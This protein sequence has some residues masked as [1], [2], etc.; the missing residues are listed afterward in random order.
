MG[1]FESIA[2]VEPQRP[3]AFYRRRIITCWPFLRLSH[4][5]LFSIAIVLCVCAVESC[6]SSNPAPPPPP[7]PPIKVTQTGRITDILSKHPLSGVTIAG[8]D[9][10]ATTN[11]N[12][13]YSLTYTKGTAPVLTMSKANYVTRT[14][15]PAHGPDY[16]NIPDS[17]NMTEF[18]NICRNQGSTVRWSTEQS[19][20]PVF[21]ITSFTKDPVPQDLKNIIYDVI[22]NDLPKISNNF[23]SGASI[24]E[25][26][27]YNKVPTSGAFVFIYDKKA[28][29]S[30]EISNENGNE[31]YYARVELGGSNANDS[32]HIFNK[33]IVLHE[34]GHGVGFTGH[35]SAQNSIMWQDGDRAPS[36]TQI[37]VNNGAVLYDRPVGN[38]SPDNDPS[39]VASSAMAGTYEE[40]VESATEGS[41][42]FADPM[43]V[44]GEI[45][46]LRMLKNMPWEWREYEN[47]LRDAQMLNEKQLK[48]YE[49][50]RNAPIRDRD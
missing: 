18:N 1:R 20:K 29:G 50:Q 15:F 45:N 34:A 11:A 9:S 4:L 28:V 43:G 42:S 40:A 14:T 48:A 37:D 6:K 36:P 39:A 35:A 5:A 12:G 47:T 21:Y 33:S 38:S 13:D 22:R 17:F 3:F 8:A 10:T 44:T 27:D 31:R 16:K 24:I 26:P 32:E 23:F 2:G 46:R 19:N 41:G 49:A 25:E 30:S 7:P